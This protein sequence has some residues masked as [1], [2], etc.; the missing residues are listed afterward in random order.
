[1]EYRI[2]LLGSGVHYLGPK[3]NWSEDFKT[4][5]IWENSKARTIEYN[6]LEQSSD[7]KVPWELSRMQWLIPVAQVYTSTPKS[8]Y[9]EFVKEILS[10]WIDD[11]PY[12]FSINWSCTMEVALRIYTFIYFYKVFHDSES[13]QND[14]K[15]CN[16]LI[17]NIYLHGHFV[18]R[19]LELSDVNGNHYAADLSGL[20]VAA[21]FFSE[22]GETS[23]WREL[24]CAQLN[25]E[26]VNQVYDDGIDFEASVPYHRLVLELF[27][28][29][30]H[31]ALKNNRA[32][33]FTDCYLTRLRAMGDFTA[34]YSREDGS[35]PLFGDAD[36]AR[37]L[38]FGCQDLNDHR[39]LVAWC[40]YLTGEKS[41]L[42]PGEFS[43]L[44]WLLDS[45]PVNLKKSWKEFSNQIGSKIFPEGG[46]VI[47]RS[48]RVH[49]YADC[50]PIGLAGRGGHGHNDMMSIELS[51]DGVALFTDS[52]AYVYTA[53][54]VSR[55]RFR[56][57]AAHN[58]PQVDGEEINRFI[59]SRDMWNFK[60]DA[61]PN[62]HQY[63]LSGD[64]ES[65]SMSHT[66]YHRL[67]DPVH[68][69]RGLTVF[70]GAAKVRIR[71]DFS[72][73]KN[74]RY[75]IPFHLDA[76]LSAKI[77][78][79]KT[80]ELLHVPSSKRFIVTWLS[81]RNVEH[82]ISESEFSVSYGIRCA[83]P[84]LEFEIQG[85]KAFFELEVEAVSQ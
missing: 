68:L 24:A 67:R 79:E 62:I 20:Y 39:Y 75:T 30:L 15:F 38:P 32:A 51:L 9:A 21:L 18:Y 1:M 66:G 14:K 78:D 69:S 85:G 61:V 63:E 5:M 6:N 22:R 64:I 77:I 76:E 60:N 83:R 37:T 82:K 49:L 71:D 74:H 13:W 56:S 47:F 8:E 73:N 53:D 84:L 42:L 3:I 34:H 50:G 46:V 2:S 17:L 26:I 48:N 35:I 12:G 65:V 72:A 29:P 7:V 27:A 70:H 81:D 10:S 54:Y 33:D 52:G 11:N 31:I 16:T 28:L 23:A 58:T 19:N 45:A 55:N 25:S 57:T 36:D 59:D 80:V 40:N 43:E 44:E 4:G 41:A